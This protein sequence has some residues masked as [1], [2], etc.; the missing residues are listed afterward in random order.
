MSDSIRELILE[1]I[2]TTLQGITVAAGYNYTAATVE[3]WQQK[4]NST[5]LSP[6]IIIHS[7]PETKTPGPDPQTECDLSIIVE[8]GYR[9][10]DTDTT[11]SDTIVS[12]LLADIE[13][14]LTQDH[15]RG[16]YAEETKISGN[17]PFEYVDGQPR[18]GIM[19]QVEIKYAHKYSDPA[20]YV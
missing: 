14:A 4:G 13:K 20:A 3:R 10:D 11:V 17:I 15:T 9:Q 7:G 16:G 19:V 18:F 1:N 2:K 8:A 5:S 12:R 6:H